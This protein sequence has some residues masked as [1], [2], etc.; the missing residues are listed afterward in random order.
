[1]DFGLAQ[2]YIPCV[3]KNSINEVN[4]MDSHYSKRKNF[5]EVS[6]FLTINF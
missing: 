2:Q 3:N 5:D 4:Q 1:V 6:S